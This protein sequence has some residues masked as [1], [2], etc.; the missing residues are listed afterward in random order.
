[1]ATQ[2]FIPLL[3]ALIYVPL[4]LVVIINRPWQKQH[5]LFILYLAATTL[6]GFSSF[7]LV[8]NFLMEY[9]LLLFRVT[10]CSSL[11]WVVQ[12]YYFARSF[13][14]LPGGFGIWFGYAS[15]ASLVTLAAL[16][17]AP[18]SI[19][20]EDGIFIG[21]SYGWWFGLYI[22]PMLVLAGLGLYGLLRRLK[23]V[24]AP[25]ER[26]K[27]SYLIVAIGLLAIFGFT[28]VTPLSREFPLSHVGGL[29][30]AF[31]LAYAVVKHEL[32]SMNF[33]LRRG[34]GWASLAVLGTGAY[35]AVF[36]LM[37]LLIGFELRVVTLA[38]AT[39]IALLVA[40]LVYRLRSESR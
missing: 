30:S 25:E 8:S 3:A 7:L 15:L 29:L 9:K 19:T 23:I 14:H 20:F 13:L 6:W 10:I 39:L 17:Y 5:K 28:S 16:G 27:I 36:L 37:R 24:T 22:G 34:L 12:L 21:P 35:V 1:M 26:N 33:V 31:I 32:I 4:F 18:P 2:S 11:W 40:L 38:L